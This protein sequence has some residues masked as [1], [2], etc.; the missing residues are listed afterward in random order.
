MYYLAICFPVH[1]TAA[2]IHEDART[3]AY[4]TLALIQLF[5]AFNVKSFKKSLFQMNPF[6]NRTF[7]WA[8]LV[9]LLLLGVTVLI[10]G[11]NQIF[12]VSSLNLLQWGIV[13]GGAIAM[14]IIVE[15]VKIFQRIFSK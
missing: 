2:L 14:V 4:V 5:H 1:Q 7:N 15:I 12:H 11:F 10:P 6:A 13:F 8:I 3:M 9:S